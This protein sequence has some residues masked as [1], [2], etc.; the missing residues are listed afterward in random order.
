MTWSKQAWNAAEPTYTRILDLEFVRGLIDGSLSMERFMFYIEQDALYIAEFGKVLAGIAS[1]LDR[2]A[3]RA[4]FLSFAG[5]CIVAEEALH[6]S[7]LEKNPTT[8]SVEPT[9]TCLLYTSYLLKQLH[10]GPL[11]VAMA[12]VLPCFWVYKEVGKHIAANQTKDGNPFQAWIDTYSDAAFEAAVERAI[13]ACNTAAERCT[14]SE[15]SAMTAAYVLCTKME[16]MFWD[17]AWKLESWPI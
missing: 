11:P 6:S 1:K 8:A 15:R 3:D 9:P 16:W 4:S 5:D 17:S 2:T 12:S 7:Y 10:Q 13:D 14:P